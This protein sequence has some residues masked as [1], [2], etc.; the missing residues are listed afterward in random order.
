MSTFLLTDWEIVDTDGGAAAGG[1]VG[2]DETG[3]DC[4]VRSLSKGLFP[5]FG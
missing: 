5:G 3:V 4:V 1:D 2:A